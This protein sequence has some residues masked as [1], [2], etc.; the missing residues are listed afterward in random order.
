MRSFGIIMLLRFIPP[1]LPLFCFLALGILIA[2][3]FPRIGKF[4]SH[5]S[6]LHYLALS[7]CLGILLMPKI[8]RT[9]NWG[10]VRRYFIAAALK[11]LFFL[12]IG[13]TLGF[14]T[15]HPTYPDNHVI[16]FIDDGPCLITGKII[17]EPELLWKRV[18]CEFQV[19][20]VLFKDATER[21]P[22]TGRIRMNIYSPKS[23][24]SKGEYLQARGKIKGFRNF[25]NPGGFD[26]VR[27][28]TLKGL[29]GQISVN[30]KK[31]RLLDPSE[32]ALLSNG[33]DAPNGDG[34][35]A[36]S[37]ME[38]SLSIMEKIVRSGTD[39]LTTAMRFL[40][41]IRRQFGEKIQMDVENE[42]AAA[43]LMALTTGR[44]DLISEPLRHTF[45]VTGASHILAI[46]GLHLSILA[47]LFYYLF[48][49]TLSLCAQLLISGWSRKL[50]L[51]LTL[52][53]LLAYA[54]LAGWSPATQR[55][56]IMI[57]V[58]I[59]ATLVDRESDNVNSLAVAGV[60]I[61]L[62]E[63]SALYSVSFQLSFC[64]VL[65]IIA[66]HSVRGRVFALFWLSFRSILFF[67]LGKKHL[68]SYGQEKKQHPIGKILIKPILSMLWISLCAILGTQMLVMRYFHLISFTGIFTNLFLIPMIGF[69]A[70]PLGLTALLFFPIL[71]VIS[72]VFIKLAGGIL[73]W[74]IQWI[75]WVSKIPHSWVETIIPDNV[76]MASYYIAMFLCF[77]IL[78]QDR[79]YGVIISKWRKAGLKLALP[80]NNIFVKNSYDS[81]HGIGRESWDTSAIGLKEEKLKRP[82]IGIPRS[83]FVIGGIFLI[84]IA[85][86]EGW[87]LYKRF[88][89]PDLK[90]TVLSVGQGNAAV[91]S[92]PMGKRVLVDGGGFSYFSRFDT[93]EHIIAPFLR[94]NKILTLDAV[95][96]THPESDHL[97]GLVY[98]LEHFTV[99]RLI[100]NR[101]E[102]TTYAYQD[103]MRA[104]AENA[105]TLLH[106]DQLFYTL[107]F[108]DASLHFYLPF[109]FE[110]A[111]P[112][113]YND[114][115]L[116]LKLFFGQTSL[117]FPGD[118]MMQGEAALGRH[119][120]GMLKS[121]IL[122]AP[123][124]GSKTSSSDL[125]LDQV[126]PEAVIISC[127]WKNRFGFPH[128]S[129]VANY[130]KRGIT[131]YRTDL[132]GAITLISNGHRWKIF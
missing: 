64:A 11:S 93:G 89:N 84:F 132:Q 70:L 114:N 91:I 12:M 72:T 5:F 8:A 53:P 80:D 24:F 60:L 28:M 2:D 46:S 119:Y 106:P 123:H 110:E 81:L 86:Y 103:L 17:S 97:N 4:F 127:G 63:P 6:I 45:S 96:M 49:L 102:R 32:Q 10:A 47:F 109:P 20:E 51:L 128:R 41:G 85:G 44:K 73:D 92:L 66:G 101:D 76:E 54:V 115:S 111:N 27:H 125:L 99:L 83:L 62:L 124:H 56:M 55:A 107:K 9:L 100:K 74:A 98:I 131:Q 121:D 94:Q 65:F 90:V 38:R 26:Y 58:F 104:V 59:V 16:H 88:F 52:F 35:E 113:N 37:S 3:H 69:A 43:I 36:V 71:P 117:F 48:Y 122:M 7:I 67:L 21:I 50:A 126:A 19:I 22:V 18:R 108:G 13:Y 75:E 105:V 15:F 95:I 118:I 78:K 61:L 31:V 130:Q 33:R 39:I 116:T 14:F 68:P 25:N 112:F 29:W 1:V 129:V 34:D 77:T 40:S 30:G 23:N 79:I 42:D 87:A 120:S 82:E 57:S